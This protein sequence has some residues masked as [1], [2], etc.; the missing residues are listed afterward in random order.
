[1]IVTVVIWIIWDIYAYVDGGGVS[2]F[3]VI[4]TDSSLYSPMIPLVCGILM[5][6]WFW[7]AKGSND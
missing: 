4:I 5:G 3:S 6:H 7:P 2:T 1:M